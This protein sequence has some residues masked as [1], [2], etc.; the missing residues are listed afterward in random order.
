MPALAGVFIVPTA[1]EDAIPV[2]RKAAGSS[3][4]IAFDFGNLPEIAN[5]E[6]LSGTP[7]VTVTGA[8]SLPSAGAV[9]LTGSNAAG[10]AP[11]RAQFSVSGGS[12]TGG[13]VDPSGQATGDYTLTCQAS[14]SGGSSVQAKGILRVY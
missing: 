13:V 10:S 6:T 12:A 4:T 7:T 14:L 5:G 3:I 8:S 2:I 9:T 1:D 11:Y